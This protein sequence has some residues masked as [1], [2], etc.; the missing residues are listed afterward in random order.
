MARG[1]RKV[2][3]L[4]QGR[5]KMNVISYCNVNVIMILEPVGNNI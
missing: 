2:T 3:F 5:S 1:D 4:T